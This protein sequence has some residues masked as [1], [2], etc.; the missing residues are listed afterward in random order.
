MTRN[1]YPRKCK[2]AS[3]QSIGSRA[4]A[5]RQLSNAKARVKPNRIVH[6][7]EYQIL[8]EKNFFNTMGTF[9]RIESFCSIERNLSTKSLKVAVKHEPV[10]QSENQIDSPSLNQM[11]TNVTDCA[12]NQIVESNKLISILKQENHDAPNAT[13][14]PEATE[15]KHF[16]AKTV[17]IKLKRL[18]HADILRINKDLKNCYS[19]GNF[20]LL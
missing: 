14:T 13:S 17:Y 6:Q 12:P 18:N 10:S 2:T 5:D 11:Q 4:A 7:N 15:V 1:Y 20:F 16:V 3:S 9:C 19:K 8:K